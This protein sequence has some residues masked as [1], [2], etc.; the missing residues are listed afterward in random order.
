MFNDK[1]RAQNRKRRIPE[2]TLFTA[3][4]LGGSIGA[5]LGMNIFRHKTKHKT[6]TIGIPA[7]LVIQL[8]LLSLWPYFSK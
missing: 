5:L 2:K 1:V 4:W 3:A 7:I 6:F 8:F